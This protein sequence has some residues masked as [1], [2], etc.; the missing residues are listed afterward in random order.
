MPDQPND[1]ALTARTLETT[2]RIAALLL[3]VV[4]CLRILQPFLL[5]IVWGGIIAIA[6]Y[7]ALIKLTAMLGGRRKLALGV[8][9]LTAAVV[10]TVPIWAIMCSTRPIRFW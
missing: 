1:N 7:P 3:L 4:W 6:I 2:L 8:I 10:I 9:V 5:P